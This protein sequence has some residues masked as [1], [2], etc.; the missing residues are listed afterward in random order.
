MSSTFTII[1]PPLTDIWRKPPSTNSFNAPTHALLPG[2]TPLASFHSARITFSGAWTT[3]Y[4]Q[5]GLLLHLTQTGSSDRW[6]KTGVEF[7]QGK[8]YLST[9]ATLT[10][11]DWSITPPTAGEN[12][13]PKTSTT[14]IEVRR[15]SDELGSSL[16]VY[17]L[18]L[19]GSGEILERHPLREVTW[20][21]AEEEGWEVS[22]SAMAARPAKK[23]DVVG[24]KELVAEFKDVQVDVR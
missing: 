1:A 3:R 2:P 15:E 6:L 5:C 21:F 17:E 13:N 12:L 16:W 7:Y 20:F 24:R 18:V 14:T 11:S 10:Y 4:D 23:E 9:V 19:G 8:P 22:V